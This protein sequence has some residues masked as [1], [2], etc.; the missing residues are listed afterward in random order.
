MPQSSSVNNCLL[1]R[2]GP[3]SSSHLQLHLGEKQLILQ[4]DRAVVAVT[5]FTGTSH[6]LLLIRSGDFLSLLLD[7]EQVAEYKGLVSPT[8]IRSH[9]LK[10]STHYSQKSIYR[11]FS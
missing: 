2:V 11:V 3:V 4:I 5:D 9:S 10:F 6:T 7:G 8:L 1:L